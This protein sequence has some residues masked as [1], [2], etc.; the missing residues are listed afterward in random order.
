M[1]RWSQNWTRGWTSTK[2]A[3]VDF[4]GR[5]TA[6]GTS[7]YVDPA[8]R[9]AVF[10]NDGTLWCEKPMPIQ[11][12]FTVRRLA[13]M[14]RDDPS[15]QDHRPDRGAGDEVRGHRGTLIRPQ[16]GRASGG[17]DS[18]L[19]SGSELPAECGRAHSPG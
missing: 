1:S 7:D 10:D 4:V 16:A 3:I 13:D 17:T 2:D 9:V 6:E 8:E 11:L 19:D 18:P 15:L 14:A 5:V 12:D